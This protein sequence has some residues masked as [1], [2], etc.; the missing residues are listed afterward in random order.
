LNGEFDESSLPV[1]SP[2]TDEARKAREEMG[3][4]SLA[5]ITAIFAGGNLI[6]LFL[7]TLAGFLVARLV[8]PATLGLFNG[9][10]LANKYALMLQFG[11]I[12]GL[13]REI[14]YAIGQDDYQRAQQLTA[15][16][17]AWMWLMTGVAFLIMG[18]FGVHAFFSGS[19]Q[20]AVGW[21]TFAFIVALSLLF[22]IYEVTYRTHS[23][24]GKLA[25]IEIIRSV[26]SLVLLVAVYF[27]DFYGLCIRGLLLGAAGLALVYIWRPMKEVKP[28][29]NWPNLK[30]LWKVGLPIYAVAQLEVLWQ[31]VNSTL[32]LTTL[33]TEGMGL[34]SLAMTIGNVMQIL[35]NAF[36]KVTMPRAA[37]TFGKGGR[38]RSV[39]GTLI[40]PTLVLFALMVPAVLIGIP[41]VDWF[42]RT[43]LPNYIEGILAAQ[44]ALVMAGLWSL[45]TVTV[46]LTVVRRQD[47]LLVNTLIGIAV[48]GSTLFLLNRPEP[49]I[50]AFPQAMVAGRVAYLFA[51]YTAALYLA[52]KEGKLPETD[53]T[54][55][56]NDE[57]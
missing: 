27:L 57:G 30:D 49:Y 4:G 39:F 35:P 2:T 45:R 16:G 41:A 14:P 32:V 21:F 20:H 33:G 36:S 56:D 34:F 15:A 8:E 29:W 54:D 5:K 50:A 12:N 53:S 48:W 40:K 43:L 47:I 31:A 23:N 28:S 1:S 46:A 24:F 25:T 11:T 37:M 26:L 44:W 17:Y 3:K 22:H 55:R 52:R 19:V 18:G 9:F 6:G 7:R 13:A 10:G 51:G 38:F 42:T